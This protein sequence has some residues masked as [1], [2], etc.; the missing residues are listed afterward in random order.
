MSQ[1]TLRLPERST[2][3]LCAAALCA[4]LA[5]VVAL[6]THRGRSPSGGRQPQEARH[7]WVRGLFANNETHPGYAHGR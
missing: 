1:P 7:G 6:A 3:L 5:M 2:L 4:V